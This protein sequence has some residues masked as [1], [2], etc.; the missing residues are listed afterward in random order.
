MSTDQPINERDDAR[1][2]SDNVSRDAGGTG[3]STM[4]RRTFLMGLPIV[5]LLPAVL[6][7]QDGGAP[8]AKAAGKGAA[9]GDNS[10]PKWAGKLQHSDGT[11]VDADGNAQ[12]G[13]AHT[14][15]ESQQ[16]DPKAPYQMPL[17]QEEQDI[18]DGKKGPELAKVMKIVVGHGNAFG[19]PKLVDLGGAPHCSLYTGTDYMKPMI[20]LFQECADAGLKTYAPYTV[21][22][23]CYDVY[24]VN[25]NA[26]DM[27]LIYEGYKYQR[28]LDW[29]H[30]QLGAPDLN[31]RSCACYVPEVGNAPPPGTY[32]AWAESSAINYGNSALGLRTNRNAGGMELLC[33]L[34]GKAPLFGLMTDEGRMANWLVEV[35]TSKEPDL[36]VLG[37]AIGLKVIDGVPFIVGI[38]QYLGTEVSNDNM[39]LLKKMGSATAASGAVGL[40][41]VENLT[42]DA[43]QKGRKLLKKGYQTYVY[44]DAEQARVLGNFPVE[45][46]GRPEDPT[47]ALIGCPHNTYK[48]ILDWGTKVTAAVEKRGLKTAAIPT[49][50]FCSNVV[51]D[52]LVKEHPLLVGKMT[53]AKMRFTNMCTVSYAGMKGF[54][55]RT[56]GVTNS[57]KTRNYYPSVRYLKDDALLEVICTG[58]I[59]KGA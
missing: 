14:G 46:E 35:K 8:K 34:L 31:Y 54:S 50:L 51:R 2:I 4:K 16:A 22:P 40:Y 43:K 32:V 55:E 15:S 19:A 21:N 11:V 36:G 18:M 56:F 6:Q 30:A 1:K 23:R 41:H 49:K 26:T 29:V 3:K 5:P 28:D 59:P 47:V 58:K 53:E 48:E 52:H 42:P 7:A 57:P 45:W 37:T 27:E 9:G 44:D 38:D 13:F 17:T 10:A 12:P 24:N 33:G 39:H 25:N 20:D